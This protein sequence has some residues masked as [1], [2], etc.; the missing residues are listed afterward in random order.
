MFD[1]RKATPLPARWCCALLA[2]PLGCAA[3]D[4]YTFDPALLRGSVL[5]NSALSQFNQQDA[6][7]PGSYQIDLYLNGQ[8]LER[9]QIRF[10]RADKQVL[11]CFDRPQLTRFGLKNPP[12]AEAE[13]LLPGRDLKDI[14]VNADISRLRLDLSIPQA[15]LN[16]QPRGS[17]NPASLD[18]G[19][20]M[21]FVNY[22]LNQYHVSYR[23]GQTRDLDSTYANLNGGF[24][25]GLW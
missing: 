22:N 17:V 6:V 19:E 11:P 3:A 23:Q 15:L 12:A 18:S 13:C 14:A 20:S 1:V 4:G 8:F 16:G 2:L 25:L 10:V 21:A 24:N 9:D 5:S 7:A